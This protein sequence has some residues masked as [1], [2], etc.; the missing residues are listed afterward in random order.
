MKKLVTV[1]LSF[2]MILSMSLI[3]LAE[4]GSF[5]NSPSGNKGPRMRRF[6][7][8]S[9]LC[10]AE[11]VLTTYAERHTLSK[12][13]RDA[14]EDAYELI[15]NTTDLTTLNADLAT[16][17]AQLGIPGV[18][19]AVSEL[20]DVSAYGCNP[21]EHEL[22][23]HG[24]F[25]IELEADTLRNFVGLL[26][27]HNGEIKLVPGATVEGDVL[28]FKVDEL[29]PFAIVVDTNP[30]R[31]EG[32]TEGETT[33]APTTDGGTTEAP[34]TDGGTT[35]APTTDGG[36]T[37]APSTDDNPEQEVPPTGDNSN[38][39]LYAIVAIMS[40]VALVYCWGKSRKQTTK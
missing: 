3:V 36:T 28:S 23:N 20:F 12:E 10:E 33:E 17:A 26:H 24:F 8:D 18:E 35:E 34:T 32:T 39:A 30:N 9:E 16:L 21:E 2:I 29:S 13:K 25:N 6:W 4:P 37:E 5:L 15:K 11:L 22:E 14:L 31:G 27:F 19:L 1:C 40:G 7:M 38:L